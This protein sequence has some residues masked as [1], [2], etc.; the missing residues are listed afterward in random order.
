[1]QEKLAGQWVE[2]TCLRDGS[3]LSVSPSS[4]PRPDPSVQRACSGIFDR[5][6]SQMA[7]EVYEAEAKR[8]SSKPLDRNVAILDASADAPWVTTPEKFNSCV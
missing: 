4:D 3:N 5:K 6:A 2:I 8:K 1:M 7:L